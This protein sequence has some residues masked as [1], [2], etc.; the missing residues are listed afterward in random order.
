M[1]QNINNELFRRNGGIGMI[2]KGKDNFEGKNNKRLYTKDP[3]N[4]EG[5]AAWQNSETNYKV[6][7][8]NKPSLERVMDAKEWV[9]NGSK[10]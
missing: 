1:K 4:S 8:V 7:Q 5:T 2:V 6:D 9:D 3:T 10:L